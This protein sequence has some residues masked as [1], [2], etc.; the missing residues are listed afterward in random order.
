[1][2]YKIIYENSAFRDLEELNKKIKEQIINKITTM[3]ADNPKP[4]GHVKKKL[5]GNNPYHRLRSGDYRI[6]YVI[7]EESTAVNILRIAH[8]KEIYELQ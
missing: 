8:R 3:L 4:D 6:I 1:M 2:S 7:E 5:K